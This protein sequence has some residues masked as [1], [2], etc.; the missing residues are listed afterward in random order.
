M[1]QSAVRICNDD[2]CNELITKFRKP[3]VSTSANFSEL[4]SPADFSEIDE[5]IIRSADYV[6][7]TGRQT[8]NKKTP[9]SIIKVEDNGVI[10]IIRQ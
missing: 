6:V 5:E 3:V 2:F 10:K 7:N 9:S 8:S 4:P 1:D